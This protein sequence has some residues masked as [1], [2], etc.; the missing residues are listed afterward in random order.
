LISERGV[1]SGNRPAAGDQVFAQILLINTTIRG[2][3]AVIVFS[4]QATA[5][6]TLQLEAQRLNRAGA[7]ANGPNSVPAHTPRL[8]NENAIKA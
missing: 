3:A 2:N 6:K 1:R 8:W 5:D 4:T 7:A